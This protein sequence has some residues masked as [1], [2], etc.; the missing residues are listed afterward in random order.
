[1]CQDENFTT[2]GR[3]ESAVHTFADWIPSL[4]AV[5]LTE[6]YNL[7]LGYFDLLKPDTEK[8]KRGDG[9]NPGR[10]HLRCPPFK[11]AHLSQSFLPGTDSAA[12]RPK[13]S[14]LRLPMM[15]EACAEGS[16]VY[17]PDSKEHQDLSSSDLSQTSQ[18][19]R[20]RLIIGSCHDAADF[21]MHRADMDNHF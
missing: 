17:C 7:L 21:D 18:T 1:M 15:R 12:R 4:R 13:H 10:V 8:H 16:R 14:T 9:P 20:S 6:L 3:I 11:L 19:S 5:N 2:G